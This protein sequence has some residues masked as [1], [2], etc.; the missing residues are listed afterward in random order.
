MRTIFA[1]NKLKSCTLDDG[2]IGQ[3]VFVGI[4]ININLSTDILQSNLICL[5]SRHSTLCPNLLDLV[6]EL[7]GEVSNLLTFHSLCGLTA[8]GIDHLLQELSKVLEPFL[9]LSPKLTVGLLHINHELSYLAILQD[10]FHSISHNFFH[11]G[12]I[13]ILSL[14]V[15]LI[16]DKTLDITLEAC[17]LED[18]LGNLGEAFRRPLSHKV[19]QLVSN[20]EEHRALEVITCVQVDVDFTCIRIV[21]A[22]GITLDNIAILVKV[23]SLSVLFPRLKDI[24]ADTHH[25]GHLLHK[26]DAGSLHLIQDSSVLLQVGSNVGCDA[27]P[28]SV[29]DT[30]LARSF[31]CSCLALVSLILNGAVLL[32][33]TIGEV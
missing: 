3:K 6:K 29:V 7:L 19:G 13:V 31:Q 14:A 25:F 32:T 27:V 11:S 4:A 28:V 30:L 1:R 33:K 22:V 2:F 10:G 12:V 15:H 20:G 24:E 5:G 17:V 9:E 18:N 8:V 26:L 21:E 16:S 23:V